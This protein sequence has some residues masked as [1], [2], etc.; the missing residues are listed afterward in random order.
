MGQLRSPSSRPNCISAPLVRYAAPTLQVFQRTHPIYAIS[1]EEASDAELELDEDFEDEFPSIQE[2]GFTPFEFIEWTNIPMKHEVSIAVDRPVGDCYKVWESRINWMQWFDMID[3]VGFHEEE[4]SYMSMY[5]WYRWATTP[6][7]ELYVTLERTQEEE[8]KYILE[9]PVEGFPLVAAVLFTE[10]ESHQGD[11]T[12]VTLRLSYLLPKVL[13]EF[14]GQLA[15]Y[16]DVNRKLEK[17]MEKMKS[18]I[19]AV[20]MDALEE[21]QRE[22][23]EEIKASFVE[24]RKLKEKKKE[25]KKASGSLKDMSEIVASE[26]EDVLLEEEESEFEGKR[27]VRVRGS[28]GRKAIKRNPGVQ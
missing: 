19:E 6:F 17:C 9:E 10:R 28:G 24:Q 7:L 23:E 25:R 12:L 22:N 1:S 20:D 2:G 26:V 14:A 21:M 27:A 18:V 15:V 8:N 13:H 3:E 5:M 4:P 16:G 11:G